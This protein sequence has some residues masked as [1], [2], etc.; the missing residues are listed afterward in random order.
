M[1]FQSITRKCK[2]FAFCVFSF[3]SLIISGP[4]AASSNKKL[5]I[6]SAS[7]KFIGQ[8]QSS[9]MLPSSYGNK[10]NGTDL[11]QAISVVKD[12]VALGKEIY[13][14]VEKG[15]PV[16]TSDFKGFSVLPRLGGE[17]QNV[18]FPEF[19]EMENWWSPGFSRYEVDLKNIYGL[20]MVRFVF[21]VHYQ[22]GGTYEGKGKYLTNV[23][24]VL[25]ELLVRWGFDFSAKV[26]LVGITN[27]GTKENQV[28]GLT[29]QVEYVAKSVM[30]EF[31]NASRFFVSGDGVIK[32][33]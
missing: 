18:L 15:R 14:L 10:D 2:L 7:V 25:D 16:V 20:S 5:E 19:Y 28:A 24:V 31:Q 1:L 12:L 3:V 8:G 22:P 26:K 29:L 33:L 32:K 21:S 11:G 9:L 30:N 23:A 13:P 27:L 4:L 17:G 6:A